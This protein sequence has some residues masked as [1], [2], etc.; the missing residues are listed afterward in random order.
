ME[1][2]NVYTYAFLNTP[3]ATLE[4]PIGICSRVLLISN[5][6][7]S[8]LV[9]PEV[10]LELLQNDNERL[11]QAVLSHDHVMGELFRQTTVLPLRF[12]TSFA[13][14]E[15]L[16]TYLESHTEEYLEKIRQ[17]NG[18]AEYIL[19]FISRTLDEPVITPSS[20]GR[21]YFLAKKQRYQT[22][23][24]FQNAQTAQWDRAVYMIT[25]IYKSAIVVQPQGEEARIYLLASRQD[26]PLLAEQFLAWQLACD[27]W[28]LQLGLALPPYHFI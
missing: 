21:Q 6:G 11:I 4:L 1:L 28:E 23:Q 19:K 26:E 12:G 14:K 3:A 17:L 9:E 22:Q 20:A 13:S 18:K 24:D 16:L 8:A 25:Q 27:R 5:A 2:Y 7:V 10:S 15:S